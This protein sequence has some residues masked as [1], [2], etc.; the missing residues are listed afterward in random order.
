M[1]NDKAINLTK[2]SDLSKKVDCCKIVKDLTCVNIEEMNNNNTCDQRNN[3]KL[4]EQ[5]KNCYYY[6]GG[7][8]LAK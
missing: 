1:N 3:E 5:A 6:K 7:K 2:N 8:E 4:Q